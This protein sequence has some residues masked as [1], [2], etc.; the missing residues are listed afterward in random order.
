MNSATRIKMDQ[1][2]KA[3]K[4]GE[5]VIIRLKGVPETSPTFVHS[6]TEIGAACQLGLGEGWRAII[7]PD[8]ILFFLIQEN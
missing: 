4:D 8:D 1:A 7:D 6:I 5:K 3:L 2:K